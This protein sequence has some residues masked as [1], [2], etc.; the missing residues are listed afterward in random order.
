MC[1]CLCHIKRK[2]RVVVFLCPCPGTYLLI[3]A[4]REKKRRMSCSTELSSTFLWRHLGCGE[5]WRKKGGNKSVL[6]LLH[7]NIRT[8]YI[9][10]QALK[11]ELYKCWKRV[12]EG[13]GIPLACCLL[14]TNSI[15][16]VLPILS[17]RVVLWEYTTVFITSAV[18]SDPKVSNLAIK[19]F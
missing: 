4:W 17:Q 3:P 8:P 6:C 19:Y 13:T 18:F 15:L 12:W 10:I 16:T 2:R 14:R 11:L 5:T 9:L 7:L 1:L